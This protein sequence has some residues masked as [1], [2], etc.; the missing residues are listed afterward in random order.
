MQAYV[1]E[2]EERLSSDSEEINEAERE[3]KSCLELEKSRYRYE[4]A[5]RD[6]GASSS[7]AIGA[8]VIYAYSLWEPGS[9]LK[10]QRLVTEM[11]ASSKRIFEEDYWS[12]KRA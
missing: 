8:G 6:A 5:K 1:D 7:R 3:E 12:T 4:L 10:A 2:A 11:H 9:I